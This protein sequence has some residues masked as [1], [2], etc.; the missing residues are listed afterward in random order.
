MEFNN[1]KI[2]I[3]HLV[4]LRGIG[5]VQSNF[6]EF[7]N[8]IEKSYSEY[9]HNVYTIGKVDKHYK[10][11]FNV[12]NIRKITNFYKLLLDIMSKDVIVHFYN[13]LSSL[14]VA[15]LLAFLP[16]NKIV[17]HERGTIWNQ[18]SSRWLVP[19]FVAWKAS[20]ILANS[21]ATKTML[22]KKFFISEEKIRVI[23]NGI[24][25]TKICNHKKYKKDTPKFIIG[26]IGRL[27]PHKG[28]HVLIS[29]M[30]KLKDKNIKLIIAGDGVLT[31]F[32]KKKASTLNNVKFIG[33]VASP[34]EFMQLIDL[35]VVPSI[36]EPLGNVCLEAGLCKVPVLASNVD[37]IPE[38]IKNKVTGELI[39][40]TDNILVDFP[41]GVV[42][43]P[44]VVVNPEMQSLETPKQINP[45]LLAK[46][47][48]ELS[49][50]PEVL[51]QYSN[52]LHK[53]VI[54]YFNITRYRT[55]LY[56]VYHDIFF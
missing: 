19:R 56:K 15:F 35:L 27:D 6:I 24:K 26:F 28:V 16:A 45:T 43:L 4:G 14:K 17:V 20:I 18:K 10:I 40:A 47:I 36:R 8:D 22:V 37:G 50:S 34:Y 2:I 13:N 53:K 30:Q 31:H 52:K 44:E 9:Q 39:D 23:H 11:L 54:N 32:L 49:E 46:K 25:I 48:L 1:K 55:E 42:P 41:E 51:F 38:V 12:L 5:G 33:R 7:M 3:S 21:H 29:A